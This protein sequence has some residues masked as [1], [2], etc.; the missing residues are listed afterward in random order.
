MRRGRAWKALVVLMGCTLLYWMLVHAQ[1][2]A[3]VPPFAT[4]PF[5]PALIS[6]GANAGYLLYG[7]RLNGIY[8]HGTVSLFNPYNWLTATA[9]LADIMAEGL[10]NLMAAPGGPP[11]VGRASQ[12]GGGGKF[13][14]SGALGVAY[15]TY[16][17]TPVVNVVIASPSFT[18][19]G[20]TPYP[21]GANPSSVVVA[22]FNGDS[23]MDI[24]VTYQGDQNTP[25]GIAMLLNRGDGTFNPKVTYAAGAQ[26]AGLAAFDVNHDNILDLVVTDNSTSSV[27]VLTGNANGTFNAAVP[28]TIAGISGQSVTIADF[29]G[30]GNPDIAATN[31]FGS[32]HVSILLNNGNG[33]FHAGST[34]AVDGSPTYIAAGDFNGDTKLDLAV[35][36]QYGQTV[37]IYLGT[38]TGNFQ[39]GIT[40]VTSSSP[41]ALVLTDF[42]N[43]GILDVL[44]AEG[45][46]RAFGAN[47]DSGNIDVLLGNGDGTFKGLALSN[48]EQGFGSLTSTAVADFNGDGIPDVVANDYFETGGNKL[49]LF[50]GNGSGGFAIAPTPISLNPQVTANPYSIVAGDFNGDGKPDLAVVSGNGA[51]A[52][53]VAILLNNGSG[54]AAP[55][56]FAAGENGLNGIATGDFDGDGKLDLAVTGG[57]GTTV[58]HGAGNGTFQMTQTYPTGSGSHAIIAVDVNGDGHLDL[59]VVGNGNVSILLNNGSGGFAA[60]I[61]SPAGSTQAFAPNGNPLNL[62]T[63][64]LNGDGKLDVVVSTAFYDSSTF[65]WQVGVLL[66]NGNGTFQPVTFLATADTPEGL[67]VMDFNGDGKA[68]LVV[69]HYNASLTYFQG[70]GNGTFAAEVPFSGPAAPMTVAVADINKDGAPDIVVGGSYGGVSGLLNTTPAANFPCQLSST[71]LQPAAAGEQHH[72]DD[73]FRLVRARRDES[74]ELDYGGVDKC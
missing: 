70:N 4:T 2:P 3:I 56:S 59:A 10:G 64:D 32:G 37:T 66:G 62:A 12:M 1:G 26:P 14:S 61:A 34:F 47:P 49:Y 68:D 20:A 28:Y 44:I 13:T 69:T 7:R 58:F 29:N 73:C 43:D 35:V 23:V 51:F 24:A 45:D 11:N 27:Y 40:Y 9:T 53:Q 63:G 60:P 16:A 72:G 42:N 31:G 50:P 39:K 19:T 17:A 46:A 55:V 25:G 8:E 21:V 30:D 48:T 52:S 71:A 33:T 5:I 6:T 15:I 22:D 41:D 74:A 67:A 54:F 38:G 18:Y 36:D 57:N 65:A